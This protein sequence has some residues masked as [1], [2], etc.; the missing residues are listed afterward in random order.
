MKNMVLVMD[1]FVLPLTFEAE[2]ERRM[3]IDA[4]IQEACMSVVG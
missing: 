4:V 3:D 1:R 2:R